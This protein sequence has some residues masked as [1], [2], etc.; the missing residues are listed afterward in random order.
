MARKKS[1]PEKKLFTAA[2]WKLVQSSH[3]PALGQLSESQL[4][5]NIRLVRE[6]RDKWNDQATRQRRTKQQQQGSRVTDAAARSEDKGSILA[7]ALSRL[8]AQ[9]AQ[10]A[11]SGSAVAENARASVPARR[12]PGRPG[13]TSC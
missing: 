10:G 13:R 2:E 8:E 6:A 9:L 5:R 12:R 11:A 1:A 7:E 4:K 3:S